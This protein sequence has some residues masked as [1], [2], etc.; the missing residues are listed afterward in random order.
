MGWEEIS[1]THALWDG[2]N[3]THAEIKN[4]SVQASFFFKYTIVILMEL[5][6]FTHYEPVDPHPSDDVDVRHSSDPRL[7]RDYYEHVGGRRYKEQLDKIHCV[8][9]T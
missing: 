8:V 3:D 1:I 2:K 5:N 6:R 7:S 4:G 9:S